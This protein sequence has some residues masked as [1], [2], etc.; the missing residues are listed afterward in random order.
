MN[1]GTDINVPINKLQL[2]STSNQF[3]VFK[4]QAHSKATP[5]YSTVSILYSYDC[6]NFAIKLYI[7]FVIKHVKQ[8]GKKILTYVQY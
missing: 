8:P 6:I 1:G 3:K 5:M 7:N 2:S 4:V